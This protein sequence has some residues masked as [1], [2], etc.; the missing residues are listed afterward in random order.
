MMLRSL[1]IRGYRSL[2]DLRLKLDRVTVITGE[3]GVGKSNLYRA[4]ALLQGAAAGRFAESLAAEG[5]MKSSLWGGNRADAKR[6]K[7]D[8]KHDLFRYRLE[9]GLLPSD[10]HSSFRTDP[11]I[12]LEALE[13]CDQGACHMI[14]Q[15]KG[16]A[17][18]L[19]S[20]TGV[21]ESAPLPLH[22]PESMLA[23]VRDGVRYPG[24]AAIREILLSWRFYH[25]FRTDPDS[26]LRRGQIGS[27]SPVLAHDG[28]NL[29]ATLQTIIESGLEE[30]LREILDQ[31]FPGTRWRAEDDHKQF[32]LQLLKPKLRRW[33]DAKELSDG[34]LRFFCLCAALMSPKPPPFLVLNEPEAS[35]HPDL[36]P[37]LASLVARV[38]EETQ[39][40]L[41]THSNALAEAL[42]A[43]TRCR[44]IQLTMIDAGETR[45]LSDAGSRRVWVFEDDEEE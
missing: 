24:L 8:L 2:L 4:L 25:H 23:E 35:L 32:Q 5:G 19:R 20:Q 29:A 10:A 21:L 22:A 39:I 1:H 28:G 41:V 45:P 43:S 37:A 12:K 30:P 36:M 7:W 6:I 17:V 27:W 38:S 42:E 26:P 9:S 40:L 16:P 14:A 13:L 3:N 31:A 33:M 44:R 15:R 11:D 34:T 18:Q